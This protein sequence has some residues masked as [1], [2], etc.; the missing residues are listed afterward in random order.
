MGI[1][2]KG[3]SFNYGIEQEHLNNVEG[4]S[5][6]ITGLRSS[7]G[8]GIEFLQYLK[9]GIGKPYPADTKADD[10]WYWQ[11]TL[12]VNNAE[13]VYDKLKNAGYTFVSKGL[14]DLKDDTGKNIEAF[15]VKDPDGH[16]MLIEQGKTSDLAIH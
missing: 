5:L 15:I 1:E 4:A 2:R 11:T 10:I 14:V 7:A 9:P 8:P 16:A 6:H 12:F 3:E 13:Q